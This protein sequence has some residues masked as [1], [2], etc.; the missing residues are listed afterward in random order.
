MYREN[1]QVMNKGKFD[2][3]QGFPAYPS[4]GSSDDPLIKKVITQP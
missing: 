1:Y 4:T 3:G 2:P